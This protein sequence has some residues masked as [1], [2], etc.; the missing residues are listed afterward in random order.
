MK[1]LFA[2]WN[3]LSIGHIELLSMR[4][5]RNWNVIRF[6]I[7]LVEKKMIW[8]QGERNTLYLSAEF[9]LVLIE[10]QKK[11][12]TCVQIKCSITVK[13]CE[14]TN[15]CQ[16]NKQL[17]ALIAIVCIQSKAIFK[18]TKLFLIFLGIDFTKQQ[19]EKKNFFFLKFY[20]HSWGWDS[21]KIERERKKKKL[22]DTK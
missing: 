18:G 5:M 20:K 8:L 21:S 11:E 14:K 12:I 17:T 7:D 4:M 6:F 1:C 19:N 2:T 15:K 10:E 9:C 16:T 22:S 3:T 13:S